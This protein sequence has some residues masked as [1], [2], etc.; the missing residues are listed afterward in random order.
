VIDAIP[1]PK[2]AKVSSAI[3]AAEESTNCAPTITVDSRTPNTTGVL[4]ATARLAPRRRR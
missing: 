3:T 1:V 2:N 4:R